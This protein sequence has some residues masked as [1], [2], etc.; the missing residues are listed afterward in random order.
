MGEKVRAVIKEE[1]VDIY[2]EN[3][4]LSVFRLHEQL[5]EKYGITIGYKMFAKLM[6]NKSNWK[7]TYAFVVSEFFG[8]E[9]NELFYLERI[10]E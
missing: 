7:L 4:G 2:L 9:L 6:K 10:E 1:V 3:E 5:Q 8:L